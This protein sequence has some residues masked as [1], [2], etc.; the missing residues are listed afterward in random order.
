MEFSYEMVGGIAP[1]NILYFYTFDIYFSSSIFLF[2][3][4]LESLK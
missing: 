4:Y 3:C 1:I 2:V